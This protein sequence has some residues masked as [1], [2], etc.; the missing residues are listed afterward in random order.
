MKISKKIIIFIIKKENKSFFN[1]TMYA[2]AL[3]DGL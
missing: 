3:L 1:E 2:I